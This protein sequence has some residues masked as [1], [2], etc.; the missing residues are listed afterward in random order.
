MSV[1]VIVSTRTHNTH[2]T[3]TINKCIKGM[4]HD[5]INTVVNRI[6]EQH[7]NNALIHSAT[8][9][10]VYITTEVEFPH[11]IRQVDRNAYNSIVT[12]LNRSLEVMRLDLKKLDTQKS[13][14]VRVWLG[15][16]VFD[17]NC[18]HCVVGVLID[19]HD[20][21]AIYYYALKN[22]SGN[23]VLDCVLLIGYE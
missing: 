14:A 7:K 1:L 10:S 19:D 9:N 20:S 22:A 6:Y 12:S 18:S 8:D 5:V 23:W 11:R 21:S 15:S 13:S 4:K 3:N 16:P 17:S 2:D